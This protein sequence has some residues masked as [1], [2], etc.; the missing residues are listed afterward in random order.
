MTHRLR[1]LVLVLTF[2]GCVL[3]GV[4]A[5]PALAAAGDLTCT[6]VQR[7]TYSP[8]VTFFPTPQTITL[9]TISAPC[10]STSRPD[11]TSGSAGFTVQGTRSCMT[12]DQVSS[13]TSFIGWNTGEKSIYTYTSTSR[14]IAGQILVTITG[15]VTAGPFHGDSITLVIA[16]PVVNLIKCFI[17]PGVTSRIG[18]GTLVI[19]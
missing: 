11:I 9:S 16:S 19:A 14:T 8:G 3:T 17:A 18:V 1:S 2:T 13:G 10:V 12:L 4:T 5:S 7:T 6:T 15:R